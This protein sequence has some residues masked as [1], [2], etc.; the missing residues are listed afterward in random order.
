MAADIILLSVSDTAI[1]VL[2][3]WLKYDT[4]GVISIETS[5]V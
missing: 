4:F 2:Q 3:K 5:F 1:K